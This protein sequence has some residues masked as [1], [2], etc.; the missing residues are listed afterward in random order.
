[1][2]LGGCLNF[3]DGGVCSSCGLTVHKS[4]NTCLSLSNTCE[5]TSLSTPSVCSGILSKLIPAQ[6][7][8]D[9][10]DHHFREDL[11]GTVGQ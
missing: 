3:G 9:C 7:F 10:K 6:I 4:I 2:T 5:S 8:P 1:M 11:V